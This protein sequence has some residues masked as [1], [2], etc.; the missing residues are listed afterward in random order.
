LTVVTKNGQLIS[1]VNSIEV[2]KN[3]VKE[4]LKIMGFDLKAL[5]DEN[6]KIKTLNFALN[7]QLSS[8]GDVSTTT[9]DTFKIYDTDTIW[10]SKINDWTDG[11]LSLFN[12]TIEN[13]NLLTNYTYNLRFKL[14]SNTE[15]KKTIVTFVPEDIS[16]KT[17]ISSANSITIINKK[18][19]YEKWWV[20]TAVGATGGILIT[21]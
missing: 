12:G 1:K 2:E 7:A 13:N 10:Y 15:K 11:R 21:K 20:W 3:N 18:K 16:G 4:S 8:L 17:I 19:W 9:I 14:L 6:I 5:K